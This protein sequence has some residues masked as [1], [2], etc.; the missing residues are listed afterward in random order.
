MPVC[1]G[2]DFHYFTIHIE[3][4]RN[5]FQR[6]KCQ[7][8]FSVEKHFFRENNHAVWQARN[9]MTI[10][11]YCF[12]LV[13]LQMF[14]FIYSLLRVVEFKTTEV[15]CTKRKQICTLSK[16]NWM[17]GVSINS[18]SVATHSATWNDTALYVHSTFNRGH[19]MCECWSDASQSWHRHEYEQ[20]ISVHVQDVLR[21]LH[22]PKK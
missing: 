11:T 3:L 12:C 20:P 9:C 21:E 8:F 17:H 6:Y 2:Y 13:S 4:A 5:C 19:Q 10:L 14:R 18:S 1:F 15:I 22:H 16:H 7:K